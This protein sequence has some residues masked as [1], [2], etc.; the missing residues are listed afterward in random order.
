MSV[1]W[2]KWFSLT[3]S[4]CLQPLSCWKVNLWASLNSF[5]AEQFFSKILNNLASSISFKIWIVSLFLLNKNIPKSWFCHCYVSLWGW[6]G[7]GDVQLQFPFVVFL[8]TRKKK[9]HSA[10]LPLKPDFLTGSSVWSV[11]L[12]SSSRVTVGLVATSLINALLTQSVSLVG[13]Q[14]WIGNF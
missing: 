9:P 8:S 13:W 14:W 5:V 7:Q 10:T 11:I 1:L 2:S 3:L 6:Y 4:V 12:C